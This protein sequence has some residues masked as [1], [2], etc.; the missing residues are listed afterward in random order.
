M[1]LPTHPGPIS[2]Y[3]PPSASAAALQKKERKRK[4]APLEHAVPFDT[5]PKI[6]RKKQRQ[7]VM[8]HDASSQRIT[9]EM[10]RELMPKAKASECHSVAEGDSIF[11]YI[12]CLKQI[13]E[14]Q[15]REF[16]KKVNDQ[17][18]HAETVTFDGC[19]TV[20]KL[21][22]TTGV[23]PLQW[24]FHHFNNQRIALKARLDDNEPSVVVSTE[25]LHVCTDGVAEIKPES[26]FWNGAIKDFKYRQNNP[27]PPKL[28]R[29]RKT[30]NQKDLHSH[31][32][33]LEEW[34][35]KLAMEMNEAKRELEDAKEENNTLR[36]E[37]ANL[38]KALLHPGSTDPNDCE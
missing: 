30:W 5:D 36:S 19:K 21:L 24:L 32:A 9:L 38:K 31:I 10:V 2:G 27:P 26:P 12:H 1:L 6:E 15:M 34:N 7:W 16:V 3:A 13:H 25:T 18:L 33:K 28:K 20:S 29:P 14:S 17:H 4:E 23:E 11:T 22:V 8:A 35:K 37:L